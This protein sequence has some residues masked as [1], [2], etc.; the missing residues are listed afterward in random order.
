MVVL[1]TASAADAERLREHCAGRWPASRSPSASSSSPRC[2]GRIGQAAPQGAEGLRWKH[3]D[4]RRGWT[5]T[6]RPGSRTSRRDRGAV[7]R[8]RAYAT[9]RTT[10]RCE[11][12]TRWSQLAGGGRARRGPG[13]A[14]PGTYDASYRPVAVDGERAVAMGRAPTPGAG[15]ADPAV[16]DN[17]RDA[18]RRRRPLLGVH[19]VVFMQQRD[20]SQ[21]APPAESPADRPTTRTSSTTPTPTPRPSRARRSRSSA[22]GPRGTRTRST[23]RTP[24]TTSWS[25]CAPTRRRAEAEAA[26]LEVL[27]VADAASRGD[28]VMILLPDERQAEIWEAEIRDGIAAGNLLMFAHGSSIHFGQIEPP[29]GVDVG[30]VAPK[31]PGHL[32]RSQFSEGGGVPCLMAVHQDATGTP[33]T[34]CSPTRAGSAAAGRGSSRRPSRTSARRTCSASRRCSAAAPPELVQAGFETLVE[35]GYDPRL[36]YFECLH[37]LK[38]IV[39]LMYEKG[40]QGHALLDLEHGRVRRHDPRPAGDLRADARGDAQDP[41]RHPVGRVREGVDRREPRRRRELQPPA[42]SEAAP[43]S[44]PWARTCGR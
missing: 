37:E 33:A 16:Y 7:R 8:G 14:T 34:W 32:V 21:A 24:A 18:L 11:G 31:G 22:S 25:A 10:S 43:A 30:M 3:A 1:R 4:V 42:P 6:S 23:S 27:D 2:R 35:A 28:V 26:G 41:G 38:L 13:R 19:R 36:A 9:T 44:S 39:D 15:R 5:P 20:R 40:L 12:A 29:P 17:S